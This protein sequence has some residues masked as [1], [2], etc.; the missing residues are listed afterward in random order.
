[1]PSWACSWQA[2]GIRLHSNVPFS[3]SKGRM[4]KRWSSGRA[5]SLTKGQMCLCQTRCRGSVQSSRLLRRKG[6]PD[7]HTSGSIPAHLEPPPSRRGSWQEAQS[8]SRP[9]LHSATQ[10]G[11]EPS[12][13][14]QGGSELLPR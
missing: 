13:W 7:Q 11:V 10:L 1:M 3:S 5:G 9:L 4:G 8:S 12:R 6:L 2:T 14:L